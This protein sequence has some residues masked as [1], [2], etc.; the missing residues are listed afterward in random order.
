MNDSRP[1]GILDSGVGGLTIAKAIKN[2]LPEESIVFFGDTIHLPYGEKSSQILKVYTH[3]ITSFLLEKDCKMVVIACNSA[4]AAAFDTVNASFGDIIPIV[5]VIDPVVDS[6]V[7]T[8]DQTIGV[9]ATKRTIETGVYEQ[10]IHQINPKNTVKSLATPLLVPVIEE[11][12]FNTEI[13]KAVIKEYLTN[14]A[15]QDIDSLIL[16]C[17]HFPLVADEIANFYSGKVNIVNSADLVAEYV[18]QVLIDRKL[19][20]S[21]VTM[22][23]IFYVSDLTPWFEKTAKL[24]FGEDIKLE[25]VEL[26]GKR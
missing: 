18:K 15:I 21:K 10:K 2:K 16:G 19:F 14:P 9:I 8:S 13:S 7:K 23:D 1:I 22:K 25:L 3:G 12:Y 17:T 26:W 11:G 5:N 24:F 20:N 4:S 6:V